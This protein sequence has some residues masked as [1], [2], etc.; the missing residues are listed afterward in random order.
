MQALYPQDDTE[1]NRQG[2]AAHHFVTEYAQGRILPM[3]SITPNG[4]AIDAEMID[5]GM[6]FVAYASGLGVPRWVERKLTMHRLVHPENEGTPDIFCVDHGGHT[7]DI[8][9]YKYGHRFVDPF[10]NWQLIDYFAGVMEA[11]RLTWDMIKGWRVR[12]TIVQPRNYHPSGPIRTWECLG[13]QLGEHVNALYVA[14]RAAKTP[15]AATHTGDH[16]RD[17]TARHACPALREAGYMAMDLA[18]RASPAELPNEALGL[19]LRLIARAQD[20]LKAQYTGLEAVALAKLKT[21][22]RIPGVN[23][24]R[25]E[26]RRRWAKPVPEI[27]A[28]G[29]LCGL[30]LAKPTAITPEQAKAAGLLPA[31]VA[32]YS[33]KPLGENKLVIT[34][35]SAAAKAFG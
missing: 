18:G 24:E 4:V 11:E 3:G 13:W 23:V 9:D 17:C 30:D 21:G 10:M 28:L 12:F 33:E 29:E 16:C 2:T 25:G 14:A 26:G 7:I 5:C 8:G 32:T 20:R 19:Q 22:E 1:E 31:L 35:D 15:G 34:D 27:L 6:T